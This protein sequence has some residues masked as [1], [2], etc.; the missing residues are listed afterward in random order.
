MSVK[1]R[2]CNIITASQPSYAILIITNSK[3]KI[4]K[5][6]RSLLQTTTRNAKNYFLVDMQPSYRFQHFRDFALKVYQDRGFTYLL[7]KK[8]EILKCCVYLSKSQFCRGYIR[9]TQTPE[10]C[11][12]VEVVSEKTIP[13]YHPRWI[14]ICL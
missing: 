5:T 8:A 6:P 7:C 3:Q 10:Q 9:Y 13:H 11:R 1:L 2:K 12:E 14:N 4:K